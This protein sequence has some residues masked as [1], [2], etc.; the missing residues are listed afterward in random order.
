MLKDCEEYIQSLG[1]PCCLS[2]EPCVYQ[3]DILYTVT[4]YNGDKAE[5]KLCRKEE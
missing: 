1:M 5:V 2:K 4:E 3:S